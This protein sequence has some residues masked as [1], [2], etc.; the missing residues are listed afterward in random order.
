MDAVPVPRAGENEFP[1]WQNLPAARYARANGTLLT[2]DDG[3]LIALFHEGAPSAEFTYAQS[4]DGHLTGPGSYWRDRA[5]Q[6]Y[7]EFSAE[8]GYG[9]KNIARTQGQWERTNEL[10]ENVTQQIDELESAMRRTKK[11]KPELAARMADLQAQKQML[12]TQL[13]EIGVPSAATHPIFAIVR[14]PFYAD[15]AIDRTRLDEILNT[16]RT[17]PQFES[18]RPA[19]SQ[20]EEQFDALYRQGPGGGM[21]DPMGT[22]VHAAISQI[23][24]TAEDGATRVIGP[25]GTNDILKSIGYDAIHNIGG[26]RSRMAGENVPLYNAW[27][28][29]DPENQVV[30]VFAPPPMADDIA[31]IT[32]HQLT[33]QAAVMESNVLESIVERGAVNDVDVLTANIS[34]YPFGVQ[35]LRQVKDPSTVMQRL[36]SGTVG[37]DGVTPTSYRLVPRE[38]ANGGV[39]TFDVMVSTGRPI[40]DEMAMQFQKHGVF[41]GMHGVVGSKG[42]Q[43]EV[44]DVF[45]ATG[46]E[47]LGARTLTAGETYLTVQSLDRP[48]HAGK[49]KVRKNVYTV[50]VK[51]F[52]EKRMTDE[53]LLAQDPTLNEVV[54]QFLAYAENRL[55]TDVEGLLTM[56]SMRKLPVLFEEY[57]GAKGLPPASRS[58]V[59]GL[60]ER[61]LIAAAREIAGPDVGIIDDVV[62]EALDEVDGEAMDNIVQL[63]SHRGLQA[64]QEPRSARWLVR[65]PRAT[66]WTFETESAARDFLR[67]YD[68]E[69]RDLSPSGPV[70]PEI[71]RSYE[72]E[73]VYRQGPTLQE[74]TTAAMNSAKLM[75]NLMRDELGGRYGLTQGPPQPA[76]AL[77]YLPPPRPTVSPTIATP[78]AAQVPSAPSVPPT[79]PPPPTPPNIGVAPGGGGGTPP[80][81]PAGVQQQQL[82]QLSGNIARIRHDLDNFLWQNVM[83]SRTFFDR[84]DELLEQGGAPSLAPGQDTFNLRTSISQFYNASADQIG[85]LTETMNQFQSRANRAGYVWKALELPTTPIPGVQTRADFM[86]NTARFSQREIAAVAELEALGESIVGPGA[87][88]N[89]KTYVSI[90]NTQMTQGLPNPYVIPPQLQGPLSNIDFFMRHAARRQLRLEVPDAGTILHEYVRSYHWETRVA[91]VWSQTQAKWRSVANWQ[92]FRGERVM[93]PLADYVLG[94]MDGVENGFLPQSD[95]LLNGI[96]WTLE[97]FGV[98]LTKRET[99]GLIGG[100]MSSTY[101]ALLGW[102]PYSVLRDATQPLMSI[103]WVGANNLK[104]AYMDVAGVRGGAAQRAAWQAALDNGWTEKGIPPILAANVDQSAISAG[105]PLQQQQFTPTQEKIRELGQMVA[106]FTRDMVPPALRS[107]EGTKIDPLWAY[108]QQGVVARVVVGNAAARRFDEVLGR[109]L[110]VP[111]AVKELGAR[112]LSRAQERHITELLTAGQT[113]QARNVYANTVADVTMNRYGVK[114]GAIGN[115][116]VLGRIGTQLGGHSSHQVSMFYNLAKNGVGNRTAL[117]MAMTIGAFT[118][119]YKALEASTGWNWTKWHPLNWANSPQLGGPLVDPLQR[120]GGAVAGAMGEAVRAATGQESSEFNTR[121]IEEFFSNIPRDAARFGGTPAAALRFGGQYGRAMQESPDAV[122]RL[123]FTGDQRDDTQFN[124]DRSFQNLYEYLN[125]GGARGKGAQ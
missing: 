68:V 99:M 26:L 98:P 121:M 72:P 102:N 48:L 79:V 14:K 42:Q 110:T 55:G 37:V 62:R 74:Q 59:G 88:D 23:W 29:L 49:G 38:L 77:P 58:I 43:V 85:L 87:W 120:A 71:S 105:L 44:M 56:D 47:K 54:G 32:A 70:F 2:K 118:G 86:Q 66:Q 31:G 21:V 76:T 60:V 89:L 96:Q 61:E 91:P 22:Q 95:P 13:E 92:D 57:A 12:A 34:K 103:P 84:M 18:L 65:G 109:P 36:T 83:P 46:K 17:N 63:A 122:G 50:G 116:L 113:A 15:G 39:R 90:V 41:T 45:T 81:P 78:P 8:G 33:K 104:A 69:A 106:D 115:H 35:V 7:A 9:V 75:E 52:L 3:S 112:E 124:M 24:H 53:S 20:L 114:E 10:F 80:V 67:A 16:I 107:L 117:R 100:T 19:L 5:D 6:V 97:K 82:Q 93:R 123:L 119:A 51:S 11:A 101:R 25:R 73:A 1:N 108:T 111:Q 125:A 4:A 94:W 28:L 27:N 64:T 30:R 40:T